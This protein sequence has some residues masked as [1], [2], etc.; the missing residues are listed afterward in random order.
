VG[1]ILG[2]GF[3]PYTGGPISMIDTMGA[4][5]FV[6]QCEAL[7]AKHGERFQPNKLLRDMARKGETF[8]GRFRQ[9]P[10][11]KKSRLRSCF[12]ADRQ[13]GDQPG[14]PSLTGGQRIGTGLLFGGLIPIT[15]SN[16][17]RQQHRGLLLRRKCVVYGLYAPC[18]EAQESW[19]HPMR[20]LLRKFDHGPFWG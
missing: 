5:E 6:K 16:Q 18:T 19:S 10:A 2:W 17:T 9:A 12:F 4:A 15:A 13:H 3:A 8:Y 1:A 11:V 7:A 14:N 20:V